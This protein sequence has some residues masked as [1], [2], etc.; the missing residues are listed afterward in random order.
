MHPPIKYLPVHWV[1]GMKISKEHFRQQELSVYDQMRDYACFS[2]NDYNYGLLPAAGKQ[3]YPDVR[4]LTIDES[5]LTVRVL[6]CRAITRG[7]GRIEIMDD[8]SGNTSWLEATYPLESNN[9]LML[10]V[11]ITINPYTR[12]PI[13][14]P[15]PE[16]SP[17]RYPFTT[18][19]CKLE[20]VPSHEANIT[21]SGTYHLT[22]AKIRIMGNERKLIEQY[23]PPSTRIESHPRLKTFLQECH[24]LCNSIYQ[25]AL[26]LH[27]RMEMLHQQ[28][29]QSKAVQAFCQMTASFIAEHID[30]LEMILPAQPPAVFALLFKK[31]ARQLHLQLKCMDDANRS[32]L[33]QYLASITGISNEVFEGS[34]KNMAE[35]AFY[36]QDISG[37]AAVIEK[38]LSQMN[39]IFTRLLQVDAAPKVEE[40]QEAPPLPSPK[41]KVH[42]SLF[43]REENDKSTPR[44]KGLWNFST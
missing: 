15:D 2:L 43:I 40:K 35:L 34:I 4:L 38:F 19:D 13:G 20:I 12:V 27:Q 28:G 37:A 7:G 31:F 26:Q 32:L 17:L 21:H 6:A 5:R 33:L 8:G 44:K 41:P 24:E 22:V 18:A 11:I 10:D 30:E 39:Q 23:V 16:E 36:H 29:T 3:P 1:N 14:Q 9:Q 25:D 42:E